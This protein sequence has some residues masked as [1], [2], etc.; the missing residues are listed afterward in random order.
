MASVRA[1]PVVGGEFLIREFRPEEVFTAEDLTAEHKTIRKTAAEFFDREVRPAIDAM[2][3]GDYAKARALLARCAE[4]GLTAILV[5][6]GYG[7]LELDFL[8][9]CIPPEEF[10]RDGS[11]AVWYGG[12]TGIGLLPLVLYGTRKQKERYLPGLVNASLVAAY[13]LSEPHAG[14]DATAIRTR[15]DLSPDGSHYILNGQKMWITNGSLADLL[16]VFAKVDGDKFTAFLVERTLQGLQVG[17]EE[18][19]MGLKGSSTTPIFFDNVK[20]PVDNVLGEVGQ[21]HKLAFNILNIGRLK[22][23]WNALGLAKEALALSLAYARQRVAFGKPIGEFGLIQHKLAEMASR[24][25]AAESINWRIAGMIDAAGPGNEVQAAEEFAAECSFAKILASEMLGYCA[26]EG[27]Q[28]HGGYGFHHDYPIERI[29][30]DARIQRIFEGTNEINR[31]AAT[32]MLIKRA[33]AKRL[34]L[35]EAV[36]AASATPTSDS[37]AGAIKRAVLLSF[38]AAFDHY[39]AELDTEQEIL[40]AL[41]DLSMHAFAAESASLRAQKSGSDLHAQY[42]SLY[43]Q[44]GIGQALLAVRN[45]FCTAKPD[46]LPEVVNLLAPPPEDRIALRRQIASRLLPAGRYLA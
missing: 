3:A 15:A 18:N 31:I 42:A 44:Y 30:R 6:E 17:P 19:K 34:S 1:L 28:I 38:G 36:R 5:P 40:A 14:S 41:T 7:G 8:S 46:A 33:R 25:Y 21:G 23:A 45:I 39:G 29:Y 2:Q 32:R 12:Q 24:I 10:G 43:T 16:T 26:D 22:L 27:V 20:V 11:F 13:C 9:A 4:L 35:P 37:S